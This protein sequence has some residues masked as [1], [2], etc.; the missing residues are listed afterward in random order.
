[1]AK[2]E[3]IDNHTDFYKKVIKDLGEIGAFTPMKSEIQ[4]MV[5]NN[6]DDIVVDYKY[7][8]TGLHYKKKDIKEQDVI[9]AGFKW[10][11]TW[12]YIN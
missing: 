6:S 1:M 4:F 7:M 11:P 8:S 5:D 2:K 12:H 9:D 10:C 3:V